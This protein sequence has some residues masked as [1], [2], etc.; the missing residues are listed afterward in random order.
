VKKTKTS[1]KSKGTVSIKSAMPTL[2]PK[3]SLQAHSSKVSGISWGNY[4]KINSSKNETRHLV[5]GSWDH[6]LKVWDV[7]RQDCLLTL[8]GSRVVSCLDTSYHSSGTVATGHPDCTVRLWDTR[9][10]DDTAKESSLMKLVSDRTFRPS[11]KEWISDVQWSRQNPYHLASTSHDGTLKLWDIRSPL[12][13][14]T[15][16]SFPASQKGLSLV[17]GKSGY[18]FAGGTDCIVK[19]FHC[20]QAVGADQ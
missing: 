6:S 4:E 3:W 14:H 18:L 1:K 12:P 15:V 8:N 19:Q 2:T 16:R 20:K 7:E 13:L 11:H 17:Y 10:S 5:T 9:T